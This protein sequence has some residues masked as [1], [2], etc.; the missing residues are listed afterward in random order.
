MICS[1]SHRDPESPWN[2]GPLGTAASLHR[3]TEAG[4]CL[5]CCSR[6]DISSCNGVSDLVITGGRCRHKAPHKRHGDLLLE[7]VASRDRPRELGLPAQSLSSRRQPLAT[8][9]RVR[10]AGA[11]IFLSSHKVPRLPARSQPT[12]RSHEATR[13]GEGAGVSSRT[14]HCSWER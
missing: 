2:Q 4:V 14:N 9:S 5:T 11:A 1:R 8:P 3:T 13:A 10:P 12:P 6:P 7:G